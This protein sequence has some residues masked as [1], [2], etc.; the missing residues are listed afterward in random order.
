[1]A[2]TTKSVDP[3]LWW[4]PFSSLLTDLENASPSDDLPKPL[5]KKLKENHDWFVET[6]TRFKPP[7]EKSKE[8]L[9]SQQIKIGPHELTVKPDFRDK[10][11]QVSSYLCLDE[12]Q[13][14]ILVDRYLEQGNAAENYIVHDSIHVVLLQ[15]YIERQCLFKCTRQILMHALFLGNILKEGSFIREEALKLISDGLEKKLISVLE[16]LMS[17]SHPEQMDV[18][19][20]TLWAEET[21]LED[22]LVLDIIFL[23][24][25]ESLCTCSAEKWKKLCLI[26]KGIL[27]GSYNFGKLAISPEALYSFYHAKV[28]LLLVLIETLNLENLLQMVHDEIPFRQGASVFKLNDVQEID[29]LISSFDIFEMREAGPLVLAWAVFLCLI[30]SLP[31][32]EETNVLMEIDHVGYVRQAFEASSLGYFLEIL[33]SDILKESDGPV[34]GYRSVL[35]TFISAFIASYEINLQLEDGTLNLILDILCYV[36]RGEE[37]LCIQF[38]DRASFIDGPIR[39]LLCNLEGEFPFRTVELLRLLSSLCEG[40]WPAE[41]VYNFLDKSTGISSLFDITSESLLDRTSQIVET[42]HPVCIP[43]VD[44]LHIPSRTR[45]HILKVVGGNTALVRWEH[46]KSAVFV[47]LLR[48]AQTPHLEN[49]EE[50]FLT[51]DLLGRMVS[52]NMAVCFSMMDSCNFLHVQATGMNGQIENNLWVV[53]IIS[54]IVRNLSPSPSGAALMSM[55]FVILAKMLKCSPSQVAAIA[56]KSN[57]FDVASNSSVFNVGWNGLSSGSWLLS[58]KLAKMLLIDSEQSDY[59]C[60]LTISVLDF[61]MQLV[62][63]GVEDDIVVSLIV[64]SLQYILVNHEYWKYKV[65]NTRWKVTLKVLEVMKTCILA[66]SSS[67]KLGGVIWDLL[68]YD[69]SIHNTLFRI[70]CTTSEALERLYLNRLIELVEIEGLQ[71]AISSALDISYIMLTKFSKDMSSSIPAFHQAM[72]SSMTKPIPVVAAVISLISFF[73]DPVMQSYLTVQAIQ[74]GAAKLLSVLLRMAEPYPFVN[75]CFGPDDKLMTDLRH[76]I[77]S[78]LLEHGVL[79]EDLFIA[80]LNLLTSAA[81]YQ[82]AFF[83]AIFDTKED[84]DVQLATAGGLKQSTNEALSDSLGSKISSVVDALLQ[85]VVRSDNAVNS[86]PCI[87]LNVLNLLKSLWHGAGL[88]TMIL[89]RLKS[90]D[91]FWKQLSNSISRTAG[92]EVPLSMK[93]SEALHLGYRY[94][95]QSAILETMAY[96]MFLMKKLLYAESL[97]KE[98]PESNKKIEADNYALKDIISNWCKSSVLGSMIKS[99]TSCK[100]DNDTYFRAKVA[101]SLLTVHIMGKLAAGDAGSLSV[102]LVEKIRLLFKKLTIQPAFSELLAQYSQRGYSEGKELKALI[103]SDLYYHL[104]GELEGRKMS[105][106]PFKELFQFLIESKVVKIYENKCRVDPFSTADD[107]YVFDLQRIEADLGLDM[108]DYS[109]WKTSKTIADTMLCYM[110]G[111][112]SMVLIG[113]SKL[114]SLKALITVLTVYDDSSL[115]KMMRVGGKIP[116]QLILPCIDH[117]CQSFL[118]TLEFLT[119]VPDVSQGVF[120]FLT[121]QADLLLHLMRSVQNSLSSSAC[122]LVLKTSGTGLKV[123]SDLRTM[124][125]GVNKTMKLLLMLILSAVEFY[126]LDSSITG[127]K[128]KESVEGFAEISNVSLGLLPILCNCITISECFSLSL[129]ALDLALKC[130]LTPDTWFPIIHKHLQL[131]HVVL[132]LQDKNYFGSIPILLKFFLA[133]AHV[134][135]GAEML[136]NAGFFSSLKVLYADMS[137][138][139]VSSVI[140]SGKSLSIL[141]DKTE[142]PQHIWGLGLAV[143]TAIVHS[144]GASS[145]CIDIAEN[146]IPYFFSEKAHLISYFLSAPEFPSDDHD[147]KR[148][149]AQRTWTSLSSLKE[150]EQ[151]LM[152]MCVLARHW[153]SWV[154]AMKNMD[155]PLRE[156]SI[157]LL[158]FISRGNQR[159]GEASSR[160]APLLCPPILKDEFDCCKKPSFVNSRNGWFALSPLGCVSKPKFSGILT[161]TALVIKDQGTESNNHVPQTYFSDLVA[162]EMYRITFLLLKFLCL[163]AEG[164]AKRAEEL[165]YVD[166]A[167]FPELPMPEILHG[168]QD[169]AIAIVTELCETNKLKQ[170]HYELQRVCL[171]LLQIMEMAL[172]LELCVLQICGIRPVLGRVEDLS[173]EL[174]FLIKATEG[175]AFLK[176]S[177]K[178]LNQII[179]LVYPGLP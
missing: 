146:V 105:P 39:C 80:V 57:I 164:A 67:E 36:Y 44:G 42:Q 123:L 62:R 178:S 12:V 43:G 133:I 92:S 66:T 101:L 107:V 71:L 168:I 97:I 60:L 8:A 6:V 148:P 115:E 94:Q 3:S 166:L 119:P 52:F 169:Q 144:L 2:T 110:Q 142:K 79:N 125:S 81:C 16:A 13:S 87:P 129:T 103:I 98:P 31:Q 93:E 127:V 30:S 33:Q 150:T 63:T 37:S 48:L 21:L 23:I 176:G 130:F 15:Y 27:S 114:S 179:S 90:S 45:G 173:K 76:S 137:D 54:I 175:H 19:L 131:Q 108:W 14:Y 50:A 121:A 82:P 155:S 20:F 165:G 49:N 120:D 138:G 171:L 106:G 32:K 77:N 47:L 139:R 154:K 1:M 65:K 51:L 64:F 88:Y 174:K 34:A 61:T 152:L 149:R 86:N 73:N 128:D 83:V 38:W 89:E 70:M 29:A 116:D 177:M 163:Q 28:Q 69:S 17:C 58:G 153:K 151:T 11:L 78:I 161:T 25:Y 75:S 122:V 111:A 56:L 18:D 157:H 96:D 5:V 22:N 53:E 41:C 132:K 170:I 100:Y 134:R 91:K 26:Y 35:R 74:V 172:Y 143:V 159:L 72:L 40:S 4:E 109:E 167:H 118:D 117:I 141:S 9:N 104:H 95:C 112:N 158:A 145:S 124:V 7:N 147:K 126:R 85:Y 68:L 59:D 102:S 84:T 10:A 160:T 140:N 136:L 135:G 156:M 99:Y 55:A 113:N 24:Y 162:I 46:K